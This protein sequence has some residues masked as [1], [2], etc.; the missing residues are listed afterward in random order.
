MSH[1]TG[2]DANSRIHTYSVPIYMNY[3]TR[4]MTVSSTLGCILQHTRYFI[5]FVLVE[6]TT[7]SKITNNIKHTLT[8]K[9]C[10][11]CMPL[12]SIVLRFDCLMFSWH[13]HK[14]DF[15]YDH[16]ISAILPVL[17]FMKDIYTQQ[18]CMQI[19]IYIYIYIYIGFKT[20][21]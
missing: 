14:R 16:R 5:V 10:K 13:K 18:Y 3:A 2:G 15:I 8:Q 11:W 6:I 4:S 7:F 12:H 21:F 19:Y 1:V 17:I 9:D 20:F